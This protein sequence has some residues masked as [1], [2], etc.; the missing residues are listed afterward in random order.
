MEQAD[1]QVRSTAGMA[2]AKEVRAFIHGQCA[3]ATDL[4]EK[5]A[6]TFQFQRFTF[7]E[8]CAFAFHATSF[9][10]RQEQPDHADDLPLSY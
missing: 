2:D 8:F 4:V 7:F 9:R 5:I 10:A 6:L 1:L 3:Q